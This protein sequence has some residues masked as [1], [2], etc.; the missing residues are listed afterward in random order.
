[1]LSQTVERLSGGKLGI[2][3]R[4]RDAYLWAALA[5]VLLNCLVKNLV[6]FFTGTAL[7]A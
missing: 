2:G 7:M 3:M 6:L 5:L 4:Y 1:M